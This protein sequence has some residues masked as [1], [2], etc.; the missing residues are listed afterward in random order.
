MAGML[1]VAFLLSDRGSPWKVQLKQAT[2]HWMRMNM[3][4]MKT[5]ILDCG[6][7]SMTHHFMNAKLLHI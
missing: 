5:A 3:V 2:P 1:Y 7:S 4:V 6:K